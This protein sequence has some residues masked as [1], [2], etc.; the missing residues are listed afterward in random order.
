VLLSSLHLH[1]SKGRLTVAA[2]A[3]AVSVGRVI[4]IGTSDGSMCAPIDDTTRVS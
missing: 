2:I 3:S 4:G 1:R